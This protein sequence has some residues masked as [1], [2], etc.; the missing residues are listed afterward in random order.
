MFVSH[1]A[2]AAEPID[3]S[4]P[5]R[6]WLSIAKAR[7]SALKENGAFSATSVPVGSS[8]MQPEDAAMLVSQTKLSKIE[9]SLSVSRF[10]TTNRVARGDRAF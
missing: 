10:S 2:L 6:G 8:F 5:S 4:A 9:F 3:E 1:S 7:A